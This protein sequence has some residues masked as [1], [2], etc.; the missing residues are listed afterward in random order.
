MTR[1]VAHYFDSGGW[2]GSEQSLLHLLAHLDRRRWR[3]VLYHHGDRGSIRL[4]ERA[5]EL[6]VEPRRLR[7]IRGKRAA[8]RLPQLYRELRDRRPA[9]FHAHL[10]WPLACR[11]ELAA[12]ALARVPAVVATVQLFPGI[13]R[14]RALQLRALVVPGVDRYIAVSNDLARCLRRRVGVPEGKIRVVH[15]GIP[16]ERFDRPPGDA[17]RGALGGADGRPI[18]LTT[19]RLDMLKGHAHLLEAAATVPEP[20]F[21]LAG[22]GPLR[23]RLEARAR[24]L[25]LEGRVVFLGHRDD[26]PELLAVADLFVLPSISEGL[27]LSVVEAMAAGKPV[28]ATAIGGID[29]AVVD[30]ETGI[31][32]PPADPVALAAAIRRLL[33]EGSFARRLGEAG[34]ARARREFSAEAMAERIG[35]IYAEVLSGREGR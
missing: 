17:L 34:R 30:G 22:E 7:R 26:V 18:V 35:G 27:P 15:N 16:V 5:L 20:V 11:Y 1:T 3:P 2:G 31:L 25:G 19:A 21:V 9:V 29:E 33:A 10:H 6:G 32:V 14:L 28:V 23:E 8:G 12:A 24:Q 4:V 13:S